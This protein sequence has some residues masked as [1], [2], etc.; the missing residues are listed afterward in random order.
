MNKGSKC[1][2]LDY[3]TSF[4]DVLHSF[5]DRYIVSNIDEFIAA[6]ETV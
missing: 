2:V 4:Y 3:L 1:V 5:G 6:R